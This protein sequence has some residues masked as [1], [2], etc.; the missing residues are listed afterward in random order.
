[1]IMIKDYLVTS[2]KNNPA[3]WYSAAVLYVLYVISLYIEDGAEVAIGLPIAI[4]V[5]FVSSSLVYYIIASLLD[6][7]IRYGAF[8]LVALIWLVYFPIAYYLGKTK[9][10]FFVLIFSSLFGIMLALFEKVFDNR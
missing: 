5:T 1:M 3:K 8:S 2:Y 9:L 7:Q 6:K 10:I 4:F